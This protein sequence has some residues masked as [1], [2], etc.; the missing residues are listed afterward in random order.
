MRRACSVCGATRQLYQQLRQ[1]VPAGTWYMYNM[2]QSTVYS[3][4]RLGYKQQISY[5]LPMSERLK[6]RHINRVVVKSSR[7]AAQT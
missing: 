5:P 1:T 6:E 3:A 7:F 2:I 4:G